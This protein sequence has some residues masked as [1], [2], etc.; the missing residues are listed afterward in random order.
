[1]E[2]KNEVSDPNATSSEYNTAQSEEDKI[3]LFAPFEVN[4]SHTASSRALAV[5]HRS[6]EADS[7]LWTNSREIEFRESETQ[8]AGNARVL[9]RKL[10]AAVSSSGGSSSSYS[11]ISTPSPSQLSNARHR[12]KRRCNLEVSVNIPPPEGLGERGH[13]H[14]GR[15]SPTSS[16]SSSNMASS[17]GG[18]DISGEGITVER[19][20]REDQKISLTSYSDAHQRMVDKGS[21]RGGKEEEG[22]GGGAVN[23]TEM[24]KRFGNIA[25]S[26]VQ[27]IY[28]GK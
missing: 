4:K 2:E 14:Y 7:E 22:G 21:R 20:V 17:S 6:S 16:I 18:R 27:V 25:D 23:K 5:L 9:F 12:I 28:T 8:Y 3:T 10:K 11:P 13:L 24:L 1:M 26:K 15:F 19:S